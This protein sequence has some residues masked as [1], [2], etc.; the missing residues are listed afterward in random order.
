MMWLPRR[1][2]AVSAHREGRHRRA[3]CGKFAGPP[4]FRAEPGDRDLRQRDRDV[5]LADVDAERR[6]VDD[7]LRIEGDVDA[8]VAD[9]RFVDE[10]LAEDVRF[11]DRHHLTVPP[12]V[13][14]KPGT[15]LPCA[16]GSC[17]R[18]FWNA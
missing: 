9:A 18:S 3:R 8:V 17:R 4:K 10:R 7:A 6:R 13:S 16:F 14:P 2:V 1:Y 15:V 11:V 12:R 5:R